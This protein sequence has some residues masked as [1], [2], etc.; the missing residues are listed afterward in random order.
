MAH[1]RIQVRSQSASSPRN[2]DSEYQQILDDFPPTRRYSAPTR[3]E[4][5]VSPSKTKSRLRTAWDAFK[6][7][8]W[9]LGMNLW[10]FS[11]SLFPKVEKIKKNPI[12]TGW[13]A[14]SIALAILTGG[15]ILL[16][17]Y[18]PPVGAAMTAVLTT[19]AKFLSIPLVGLSADAAAAIGAAIVGASA[20]L[21]D[22]ALSLSAKLIKMC[23][24]AEKRRAVKKEEEQILFGASASPRQLPGGSTRA[25]FSRKLAPFPSELPPEPEPVAR[26]ID[27]EHPTTISM[28]APG[29]PT[30]LASR[31]SGV[32]L[33]EP[34]G[35]E[36][37][38]TV[39]YEGDVPL[40][41]GLGKF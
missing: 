31:A 35:S 17:I 8:V 13:L 41:Q 37:I 27:P 10:F 39:L 22:G 4:P 11:L 26:A 23:V 14:S 25:I 7:K 15:L 34:A 16:S 2:I 9:I 32:Q 30:L 40:V 5:F 28:A 29:S 36:V 18:V 3:K 19:V 20:I 21:V 33:Q 1:G 6:L 38:R 12:L 24:G